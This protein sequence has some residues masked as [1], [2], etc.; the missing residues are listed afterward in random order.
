MKRT[1]KSEGMTF[2]QKRFFELAGTLILLAVAIILLCSGMVL[3]PFRVANIRRE[4]DIEK[5]YNEHISYVRMEG[6]SL[7]FTG[8]YKMNSKG[9]IAY[10]CY[11]TTGF[12]TKYFVFIPVEGTEDENGKTIEKISDYNLLGRLRKDEQLMD[13]VAADY[14][15]TTQKFIE[16]CSVSEIIIDEA[17]AKRKEVLIIWIAL[18]GL[19]SSYIIYVLVVLFVNRGT[20]GKQN[21][22]NQ[23]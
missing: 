8:Y 16:E 23:A 11:I 1:I 20:G 5:A 6:L 21:G 9:N 17:G 15:V 12:D 7:E 13:T 22:E 3:N 14:E 2:N 10:N 19:L 18:I 4:S